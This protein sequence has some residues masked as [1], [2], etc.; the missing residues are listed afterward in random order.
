MIGGGAKEFTVHDSGG[1]IDPAKS[2]LMDA[3]G[4][5]ADV[6]AAVRRSG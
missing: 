2:V 4:D 3:Y 6:L 1:A 5:E